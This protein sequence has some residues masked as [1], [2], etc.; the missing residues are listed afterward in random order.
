[1]GAFAERVRTAS[2]NADERPPR[3]RS[4]DRARREALGS[5]HAAQ[6][7]GRGAPAK[8]TRLSRRNG[9]PRQSRRHRPPAFRALLLI[10]VSLNIPG[11][12]KIQRKEQNHGVGSGRQENLVYQR[13][14][15][16]VAIGAVE[17]A[18]A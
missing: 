16:R 1:M 11:G 7:V 10:D 8:A 9:R 17:S 2:A 3:S 13:E 4:R 5:G 15:N 12:Y 18:S 6:R 14:L